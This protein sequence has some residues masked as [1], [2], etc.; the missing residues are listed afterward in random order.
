MEGF[1]DGWLNLF[2]CFDFR[3][4]E[5]GTAGIRFDETRQ[6]DFLVTSWLVISKPL[7]RIRDSDTRIPNP[8]RYWLQVNLLNV[9]AETNTLQLE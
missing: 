1:F 5:A 2:F 3:H 7:R 4:A 9:I 6:T 8:F